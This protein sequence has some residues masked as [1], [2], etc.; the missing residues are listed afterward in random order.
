MT[1]KEM[2]E[3]EGGQQSQAEFPPR[4]YLSLDGKTVYTWE[5]ALKNPPT[6]EYVSLSEH[7]GVVLAQAGAAQVPSPEEWEAI[8]QEVEQERLNACI[9]HTERDSPAW[10]Y[11]VDDALKGFD[12]AVEKIARPLLATLAEKEE[13]IK[14]L[15]WK[16][17]DLRKSNDRLG[18]D[19]IAAEE[20]EAKLQAEV[21]ELR[22]AIIEARASL[23]GGS[24][25]GGVFWRED[26]DDRLGQALAQAASTAH[27]ENENGKS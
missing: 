10:M 20:R 16:E 22:K 24:A 18:K 23:A 8:R 5:E 17:V 19:L 7:R 25:K 3:G 27:T 11:A 12:A 4:I 13:G 1:N 2:R 14:Y 26:A 9:P 21:A 15:T 6:T